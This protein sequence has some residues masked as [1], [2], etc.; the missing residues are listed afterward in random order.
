MPDIFDSDVIKD[1][2]SGNLSGGSSQSSSLTPLSFS[3]GLERKKLILEEE[4][5]KLNINIDKDTDV[6]KI[7]GHTHNPLASF[8][9]YPDDVKFA[10]KDDEEKVVLLLRRHP[11]T[12]LPWIVAMFV[13]AVIPAFFPLLPFMDQ[14]PSGFRLIIY[15]VWY[16]LTT[17]FA[18][19]K[20]LDWFFNVGIVTDERVF[21]VNFD[22]LLYREISE[23]NL[24][25]IQDVTVEIG[26]AT[27][28]FFN[29]GN[30]M[31]QTASEVSRIEFDSV[32]NPDRVSK[33]LREL[34]VEEEIEKIEGRVR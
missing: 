30:V 32:P 16:L 3:S 2:I 29:F 15:C 14:I 34:E 23:A 18:L 17:A 6:H 22:N 20:F 5:K 27:G 33:I 26:G 21:D 28:T 19:E 11:I 13:M 31:I 4:K 12:N 25:Q 7:P 8:C 24:D 9:V 1:K 10:G